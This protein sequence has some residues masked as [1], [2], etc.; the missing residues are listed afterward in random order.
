M[1]LKYSS[2]DS[3][4]N[5]IHDY[6][7]YNAYLSVT[8]YFYWN[9]LY[10]DK[11]FESDN[12][13][14]YDMTL[15]DYD[16][17]YLKLFEEEENDIQ[18]FQEQEFEIPKYYSYV[19]QEHDDIEYI[20]FFNTYQAVC[21]YEQV[22][23]ED[24]YINNYDDYF[25]D[26]LDDYDIWI[27]AKM[28]EILSGEQGYYLQ[29]RFYCDE[30]AQYDWMLPECE[31]FFFNV[32]SPSSNVFYYHPT[33]R[34]LDYLHSLHSL[35]YSYDDDNDCWNDY[36]DALLQTE[37]FEICSGKDEEQYI[38]V[39]D[40]F[41]YDA[42]AQK[43]LSLLPEFEKYYFNVDSLTHSSSSS[44]LSQSSSI[45]SS[46]SDITSCKSETLALNENVNC[47]STTSL[48]HTS[49]SSPY[50]SLAIRGK[51]ETQGVKRSR[52]DI[53]DNDDNIKSTATTTTATAD[54][55][56][57]NKDDQVHESCIEENISK[58]IKLDVSVD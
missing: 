40:Q 31:S 23:Y 7:V 27:Q 44:S 1:T 55:I 11:L 49:L 43:E 26:C 45:S 3:Y 24:L 2:K 36:E 17:T 8:K 46:S 57:G 47:Q 12:F 50:Q 41:E 53:Q 35:R 28:E 13:D 33:S 51:I 39:N 4:I 20:N 32:A 52:Y 29:D 9:H 30:D 15:S 21:E 10:N 19:K 6:Y 38:L 22:E 14:N 37:T 34:Y 58:R 16:L 42:A 48:F 18:Y 5:I 56:D 25:K 54:T